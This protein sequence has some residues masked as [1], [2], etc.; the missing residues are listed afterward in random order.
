MRRTPN[1]FPLLQEARAARDREWWSADSVEEILE[2]IRELDASAHDFAYETDGAVIKVNSF[3]Q[4]EAPRLHR[5]SAALGHRLQIRSRTGRDPAE[6][7]HRAGRPHRRAH[8]G[9]RSSSRSSCAAAPLR[10]ATLHNEDE[11]RRKD[12]RIGDTVVIEKAGEV[13]P[14]VVEVVKAKRRAARSRS[15]SLAHIGGK[16][17]ACG[18]PIERDPEFVAWRCQNLQCP[19]QNDAARRI[20]RR[21]RRA[22]HRRRRRHRGGQTRRARPRARAAR[23]V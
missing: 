20:L 2:A 22:R 18:G 17:P 8:A 10:R 23:S 13:I 21:A 3:A 19:A 14:A 7:H 12:I 11:I 9:G 15:I 4:R 1:V 6:R 5:Q 16:C